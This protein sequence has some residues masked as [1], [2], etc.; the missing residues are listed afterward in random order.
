VVVELASGQFSFGFVQ[1]NL[2]PGNK[3]T[4]W[5]TKGAGCSW[6]AKYWSVAGS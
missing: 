4:G 2:I 1:S 5:R 3:L 6:V